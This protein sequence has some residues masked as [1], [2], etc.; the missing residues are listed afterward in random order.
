MEVSSYQSGNP[1][2]ESHQG[3]DFLRGRG[4]EQMARDRSAALPPNAEPRDPIGADYH[5]AECHRLCS[6]DKCSAAVS[7][8]RCFRKSRGCQLD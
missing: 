5:S 1:A 8:R 3:I 7:T 2:A 6:A 4:T